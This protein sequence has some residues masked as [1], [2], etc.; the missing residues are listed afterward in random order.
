MGSLLQRMTPHPTDP[1]QCVFDHWY[2][3]FTPPN[4]EEVLRAQTNV[5]VDAKGAEQEFF[6]YGDR[7][8]GIIPDQTWPSL[9]ASNLGYGQGAFRERQQRAGRR[10][11]L[12]AFNH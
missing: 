10:N 6:D 1:E 12:V 11:K 7:P 8:M 4:G 3:A 2:Y 9:L 5:R